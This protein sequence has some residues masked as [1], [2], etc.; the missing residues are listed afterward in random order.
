[1]PTDSNHPNEGPDILSIPQ[2]DVEPCEVRHRPFLC[3]WIGGGWTYTN[4]KK[5]VND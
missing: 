1:M 4:C 2:A 3:H 5:L